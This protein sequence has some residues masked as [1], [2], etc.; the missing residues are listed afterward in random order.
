MQENKNSIYTGYSTLSNKLRIE[1]F[2]SGESTAVT[3]Y[4]V[5]DEFGNIWFIGERNE[6][7]QLLNTKW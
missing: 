4:K 5:V 1:P 7:E 3:Q 2:Y 6:C